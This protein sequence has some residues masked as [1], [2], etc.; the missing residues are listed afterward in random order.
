[1]Y[2]RQESDELNL[3]HRPQKEHKGCEIN[4]HDTIAMPFYLRDKL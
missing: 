1:M 3:N 2:R 4:K